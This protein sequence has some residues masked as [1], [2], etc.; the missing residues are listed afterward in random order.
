MTLAQ[1]ERY[2]LPAPPALGAL[3]LALALA[4]CASDPLSGLLGGRAQGDARQVLVRDMDRFDALPIAVAH[5]ARHHRSAQFRQ[6]QGADAVY[7]CVAP[8]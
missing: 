4:A 1:P 8:D 7:S 2:S 3:L 6:M 5:C